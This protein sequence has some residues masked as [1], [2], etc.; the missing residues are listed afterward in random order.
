MFERLLVAACVTIL[1]FVSLYIIGLGL[2]A[3]FGGRV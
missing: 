3:I 2:L 1:A